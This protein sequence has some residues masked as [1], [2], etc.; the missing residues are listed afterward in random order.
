MMKC[1]I[2]KDGRKIEKYKK[3]FGKKIIQIEYGCERWYKKIKFK[4]ND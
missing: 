3:G 4:R 1:K 2:N